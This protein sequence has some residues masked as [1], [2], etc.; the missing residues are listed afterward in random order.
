MIKTIAE[1]LWARTLKHW[2]KE[3]L[4]YFNSRTTNAYTEGIHTKIKWSKRTSFGFR[5]M[6]VYVKRLL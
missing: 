6:A 4:N 3:L 2:R 1:A 5:N